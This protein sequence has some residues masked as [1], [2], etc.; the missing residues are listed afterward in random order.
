DHTA[1]PD[2]GFTVIDSYL[3]FGNNGET[4]VQVAIAAKQVTAPGTY[5]VRWSSTPDQNCACYLIAVTQPP[6]ASSSAVFPLKLASGERHRGGQANTPFLVHGDAPWSLIANL[7]NE[8]A[9]QY[10]EDRHQKGFNALMVNLIEHQFAARAPADVYGDAP[11]LVPGDFSTPNEAY[12]AHAD[13]ILQK[14]A[15]KGMVVFLAPAYLGY[16]GGSERWYQDMA[17]NPPSALFA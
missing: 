9:D 4:A 16:N 15:A 6:P 2:N 11:F 12:F 5:T 14:A 7:T 1:V 17:G 13:L 8:Q 10:L 3:D